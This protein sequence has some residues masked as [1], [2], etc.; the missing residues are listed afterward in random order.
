M[1]ILGVSF[2]ELAKHDTPLHRVRPRR[3]HLVVSCISYTSN[4]AG[5]AGS[6]MSINLPFFSIHLYAPCDTT[7]GIVILA[8]DTWP[9]QSTNLPSWAHGLQRQSSVIQRGNLVL[10]RF[11]PARPHRRPSRIWISTPTNVNDPLW[12]AIDHRNHV[13]VRSSDNKT[14]LGHRGLP[15]KGCI[16]IS[17]Q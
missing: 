10:V 8:P 5:R 16:L 12:L 17:L 6:C 15:P 7:E 11:I 13:C 4:I 2:V 3:A 14:H 9:K 1:I